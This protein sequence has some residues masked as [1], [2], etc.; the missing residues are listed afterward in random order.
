VQQARHAVDTQW[1]AVP[2]ANAVAIQS[3]RNLFD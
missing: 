1:A 2:R 3:I